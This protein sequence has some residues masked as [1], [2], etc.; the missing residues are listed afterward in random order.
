MS[1]LHKSSLTF[2]TRAGTFVLGFVG[3]VWIARV[4]GPEGKGAYAVLT[5][6]PVLIAQVATLGINTAHVYLIGRQKTAFKPAAENALTF[7]LVVG[8]LLLG[9]Y[10]LSRDWIDPL[11]FK[12]ISS[13]ITAWVSLTFPLHLLFLVFNYL[14]LARSDFVAFNLPN[15]GR[16][17]YVLLGLILLT[18]WHKIDLYNVN[19][20][21][22]ATNVILAVQCWWL[23]FRRERFRLRWHPALFRT[24][25]RFGLASHLG[26][27]FYLL[28]WRLDIVLC[29]VYLDTRAVGFYSVAVL[30]G[31]VLWFIPHTLAVVLLPEVSQL[32][33]ERSERLTSQLCRL[34][35]FS[36]ALGAVMLVA[37]APLLV[38]VIFGSDFSPAVSPLW[39]LLP[40]IVFDGCSRILTSFFVGRGLPMTS[41]RAAALV[42]FSNLLINLWLIPRLGIMG[43]AL[44]TTISYTLGAG[45]LFWSYHRLTG[46]S[47]LHMLVAQRNDLRLL[48]DIRHRLRGVFVNE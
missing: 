32:P 48:G 24:S 23:I 41:T 39:V 44:A 2:M 28:G 9:I 5:L 45:Y 6:I 31:E 34:T 15:L 3:Q 25:L 36:S 18:P 35:L 47:Y 7:S 19:L 46:V 17:A 26:T 12:N 42:F 27:I 20:V 16:S 43:A 21:W 22:V 13:G 8:G 38:H 40:G 10:W 4:L 29:N 30:I 1:F 11:L 14:A 33:N 37:V